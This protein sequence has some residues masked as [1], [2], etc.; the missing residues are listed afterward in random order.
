MDDLLAH[1]LATFP[2]DQ[3]CTLLATLRDG[4]HIVRDVEAGERIAFGTMIDGRMFVGLA[5]SDVD[6]A[7]ALLLAV[8]EMA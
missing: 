6:A 2:D 1:F 4:G 3:A 7:R 8:G 5:D